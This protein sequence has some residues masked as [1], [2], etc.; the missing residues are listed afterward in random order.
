LFQKISLHDMLTFERAESLSLTCDDPD[1]PVDDSNLVLRAAKL[2]GA[3]PVHIHLEKRIPAGGGL[4]GGSSNAA[5]TLMV[6]DRMFGL[7][8]NDLPE[9]ALRLGSDVPFFLLG[10]TAYATGRGEELTP[11]PAAAPIPLLLLF[12]DERV[13]TRDAFGRIG[14]YS[15]PL[16]IERYRAM[17]DDDLLAH[18]E[19]LANDFEEPVFALLPR[20]RELRER[21]I[22]VGAI[23]ARMSGSGSTLVGAFANQQERDRASA[24]WTGSIRAISAETMA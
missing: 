4:G 7:Q 12:P 19:E 1:L 21:L 3:P 10:G 15:P 8:R 22:A 14:T 9:L 5:T 18:G 24:A 11:L 23:W 20:L 13:L 17:I 2:L 6:L 16:G